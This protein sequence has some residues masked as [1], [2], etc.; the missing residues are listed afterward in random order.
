MDYKAIAKEAKKNVDNGCGRN[1]AIRDAFAEADIDYDE[2]DF[3][4]ADME[5][6]QLLH[7]EYLAWA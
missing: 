5:L 3:A 7:A 4:E 1:Q 6:G 2:D